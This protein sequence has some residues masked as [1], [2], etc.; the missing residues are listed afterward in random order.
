M[1]RE[2]P[3]KL[4]R[5]L[6]LPREIVFFITASVQR[7]EEVCARVSVRDGE[8]GVGHLGAAGACRRKRWVSELVFALDWTGFL[9]DIREWSGGGLALMDE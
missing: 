5:Y 7:D 2:C 3:D 1:S 8:F 4:C 9:R 6:T